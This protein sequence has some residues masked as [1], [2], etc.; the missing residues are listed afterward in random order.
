MKPLPRKARKHERH[1]NKICFV[2]FVPFV[3]F[4]VWLRSRPGHVGRASH[5]RPQNTNLNPI[6]ARRG[7]V[8]SVGAPSAADVFSVLATLS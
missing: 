1:E 4:V 7:I 5:K 6:I 8:K 2:C 3:R